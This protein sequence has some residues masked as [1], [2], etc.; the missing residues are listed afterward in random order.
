MR[1]YFPAFDT[2]LGCNLVMKL[3]H[4][5]QDTLALIAIAALTLSP[6]YL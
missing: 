4:L 6:L 1:D 5:I 2:N 3:R